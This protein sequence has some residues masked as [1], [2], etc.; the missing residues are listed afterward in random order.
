MRT[1]LPDAAAPLRLPPGWSVDRSND[2]S[3]GVIAP[4]GDL[5][6]HFCVVKYDGDLEHAAFAAWRIIIPTFAYGVGNKSPVPSDGGWDSFAQIIFALPPSERRVAVAVVRTIGDRAYVNLIEGSSATFARRCEGQLWEI[7]GAWKPSGLTTSNLRSRSAALW[8]E[9]HALE[10]RA[11]VGS[12]MRQLQMPGVSIAV[13]QHGRVVLAEGYGVRSTGSEEPVIPTTPFMIGSSTKALSTLMMAKQVDGGRFTWETPVTDLLE[14]FALGDADITRRM[15]MRDTVSASTGMPRRDIDFVF[16]FEGISAEQRVA[17]MRTMLPTTGFGETFQY[18]NLLVAAGGYAAARAFDPHSPLQDAYRNAMTKLVFEPLGMT[19]T[20]LGQDSA[21]ERACALPHALN[22][23]GSSERIA[24][25][26][27]KSVDSV[28]PAGAIWSTAEDLA[29]YVLLEL[30][31]GK[32]PTGE[33]YVSPD[34]LFSRRSGIKIDD[35]T[36]YGLGL[37]VWHEHGIEVIG[38]G[39]NT[40]GFTSD[41]WFLPEKDFGVVALVNR[42]VAND[43]LAA[44]RQKMFEMLFGA[45]AKADQAIAAAA[46]AYAE[47]RIG[48]AARIKND[49]AS[50]SWIEKFV[51]RYSSEELGPVTISKRANDYWADFESWS[52]RLGVLVNQSERVIVLLDAPWSGSVRL[53]AAEQGRRLTL[54]AGQ[55]TYVFVAELA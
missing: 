21:L 5:R 6:V 49:P 50:T 1:P 15:R 37:I 45:K 22:F 48:K 39:G 17:Q 2:E 55:Q 47:N 42:N 43:F 25:Q 19:D 52:T 28:A 8:E 16:R 40:L 11:F 10:L 20:A 29:K 27:E 44:L 41:V 54:N 30:G 4:E 46:A 53:L 38:H 13:V 26:L 24:L 7:I 33:M 36:S 23:E 9:A 14:E 31:Q 32:T 34:V 12:A 18:S 51:G 35:Q 3:L